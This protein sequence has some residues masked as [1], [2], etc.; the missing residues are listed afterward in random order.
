MMTVNS[1]EIVQ[2]L[3]EEM[4]SQGVDVGSAWE[5]KNSMNDKLMFAVF[6]ASQ[7]CDINQ[8]PYVKSPEL[9]WEDGKYIG[10]YSHLN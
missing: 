10:K 5:Y 3:I 4:K 6:T 9:I 8:S 2:D 1:I 7:F